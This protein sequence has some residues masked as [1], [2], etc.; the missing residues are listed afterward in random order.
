MQRSKDTGVS[1]A[2]LC[3]LAFRQIEAVGARLGNARLTPA[4]GKLVRD[5]HAVC[6]RCWRILPSPSGVR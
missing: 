2:W 3:D 1:A 4:E 6:E 5:V